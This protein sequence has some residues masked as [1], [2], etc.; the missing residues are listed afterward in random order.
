MQIN[1]TGFLNAKNARLFVTEL[2]ELLLSAQENAN[3]I[4]ARF[5]DEKKEE[6][7]RRQVSISSTPLLDFVITNNQGRTITFFHA[8]TMNFTLAN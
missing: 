4:P 6:L 2:W 8:S 7:L 3:G 1:M 5:V